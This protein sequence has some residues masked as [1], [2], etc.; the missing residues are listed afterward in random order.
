MAKR[1]GT[2]GRELSGRGKQTRAAPSKRPTPSDPTTAAPAPRKRGQKGKR[3]PEVRDLLVEAIG[4][5][6]LTDK[7]ACEHAG[8]HPDTFYTWLR[9]DPDF[10][11]CISRARAR[12][13]RIHVR[14][15][16]Q[17]GPADWRASAWMLSHRF[18]DE[19]ADRQMMDTRAVDTASPLDRL[20]GEGGN[21]PAAVS[22]DY[23]DTVSEQGAIKHRIDGDD[24]S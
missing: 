23:Q 20:F 22:A 3:T 8:I 12:F 9:S 11:E 1:A 14:N 15:I 6:G 7:S 13:K 16:I 24:P 2:A 19:Y 21:E 5:Y 4:E 17:A 18:P 10:A